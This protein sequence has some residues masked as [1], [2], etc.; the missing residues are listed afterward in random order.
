MSSASALPNHLRP[1]REKIYGDAPGIPL[2][3]NAKA[4]VM[5]FAR[6][7]NAKHRQPGQHRGPLT[8]AMMEVLEALLWGFHNAA[9]GK[10]FPSYETIAEKAECHR[11]TVYEA[12]LV[13]ERANILTWVN[14]IVRTRMQEIDLFGQKVWRWRIIRTSNAYLFRDPLPCH[15]GSNH[16]SKSENPSGTLNQEVSLTRELST[17]PKIIVLDPENGLD[18]A[19]IRLGRAIGRLPIPQS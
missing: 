19:L 15:A 5:A 4:R 10:C 2:D 11:D 7:W 3:R 14:R 16:S 8:R 13:L 18:N 1:R 12:I 17:A 6:G 9:S